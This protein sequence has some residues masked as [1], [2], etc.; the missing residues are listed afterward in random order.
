MA[1]LIKVILYDLDGVLVDA[2]DWHY[3]ALNKALK[4]ISG[5]VIKRTEHEIIFNALPTMKKLELLVSQG[6]VKQSDVK[7]IFDLKQRFTMETINEN[8][9]H[10]PDK[11]ELH[12]FT[13]GVNIKSACV[14]NSIAE[15]A[16]EMLLKTGQ[17]G[18]ME[19][20]ITNEMVK[21]PKPHGEGYIRAMIKLGAM[22]ENTLI[23]EDSEKGIQAAEST[24]AHVL[25][26]HNCAA[27]TKETIINKLREIHSK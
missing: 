15:T 26:V 1:P 8:A 13:F 9:V 18:M 3:I 7:A 20:I 23:V 5:D 2:C 19:F 10:D 25:K 27:V 21:N 24:G 12:A 17:F 22:P 14:T 4:Q 11:Q 16:Y 6:R